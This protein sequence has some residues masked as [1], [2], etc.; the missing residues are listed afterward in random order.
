MPTKS[1]VKISAPKHFNEL[2]LLEMMPN[3]IC[4]RR[5]RWS[6]HRKRVGAAQQEKTENK[7]NCQRHRSF[8]S[9][10][11]RDPHQKNGS[12]DAFK[13][14]SPKLRGSPVA[15]A[16]AGHV[17]RPAWNPVAAA[18][19]REKSPSKSCRPKRAPRCRFLVSSRFNK[20][21]TCTCQKKQMVK[22][23]IPNRFDT[24][25]SFWFLHSMHLGCDIP[26]MDAVD[27]VRDSQKAADVIRSDAHVGLGVDQ[28]LVP[29]I[30]SR[31]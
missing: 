22:G 20:F 18:T 11:S 29:L 2:G 17:H 8:A 9:L 30:F 26:T 3:D 13:D 21:W 27:F 23:P 5:C 1:I 24:I 4:L 19:S 14:R 10:A 12:N 15:A 31:S 6:K 28:V 16:I 7:N 25:Q